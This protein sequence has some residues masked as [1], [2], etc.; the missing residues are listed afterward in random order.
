MSARFP[1]GQL[2][3]ITGAVA[4]IVE[5]GIDNSSGHQRIR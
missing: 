1:A 2:G 5:V 3:S 4:K